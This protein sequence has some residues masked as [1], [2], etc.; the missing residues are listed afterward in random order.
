MKLKVEATSWG[1]RGGEGLLHF[2]VHSYA[3]FQFLYYMD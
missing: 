3:L 2:A 1:G